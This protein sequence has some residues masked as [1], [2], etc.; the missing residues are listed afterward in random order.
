MKLIV[1]LGNHGDEYVGTRHN[2]GFDVVD[3]L[4]KMFQRDSTQAFKS[5]NKLELEIVHVLIGDTDV[6][7]VKPETYM[8]NSGRAV[9]RLV[10]TRNVTINDDLIVVHDE[11][12]LELGKIK[13]SVG[14]SSGNH[15]GVQSIID[16]LK[17]EDFIRVRCG[18][19][20][21]EGTL[22]DVVLSKFKKE[23]LPIVDEM[24]SKA[25]EACISIVTDGVE[26]TMNRFNAA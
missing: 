19:G 17:T 8:N 22:T 23:E 9:T 18:I 26:K 7:L 21:G 25:A 2:I 13:I 5:N 15:N 11:I 20:R 6:D 12:N 16:H 3:L 24:I 10:A 4:A 1:G 14:G